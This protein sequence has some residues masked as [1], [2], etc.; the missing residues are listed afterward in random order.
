MLIISLPL[1]KLKLTIKLLILK[2]I[3]ESKL[4]SIEIFLVKV[5]LKID[6]EIFVIYSVLKNILGHIKLK[7]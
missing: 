5:T 2:L 3:I 1:K 4:L 6:Q 7:L